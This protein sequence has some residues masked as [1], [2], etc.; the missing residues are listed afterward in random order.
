MDPTFLN[1]INALGGLGSGVNVRR[2]FTPWQPRARRQAQSRRGPIRPTPNEPQIAGTRAH[3][4][5]RSCS[6]AKPF[7]W[8][9]TRSD[10]NDLLEKLKQNSH[11]V[12]P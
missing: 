6:S 10:L 1:D 9:F 4:K 8:A 3:Q 5:T 7:E 12:A 2:V 11:P